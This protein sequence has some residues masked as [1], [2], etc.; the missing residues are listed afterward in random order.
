MALLEDRGY[1]LF[2]QYKKKL[3][4]WKQDIKQLKKLS[5]LSLDTVNC[6]ESEIA[7]LDP[8]KLVISVKHASL[9]GPELYEELLNSYKIQMELVSKDYVLGMTSIC[10][11]EEGF[12]R[13]RDALLEIDQKVSYKVEISERK[14]EKIS[15]RK[16]ERIFGRNKDANKKENEELNGDEKTVTP[17][18]NPLLTVEISPYEAYNKEGESVPLEKSEGHISKEYAYLYPPGIPLVVPGE[19]I[20]TELVAVL[21]DYKKNGLSIKGLK[22]RDYI[23]VV[24]G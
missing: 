8:S 11:T 19:R 1:S 3:E 22:K 10:D 16:R 14:S 18:K 4:A 21:A 23:E 9:T 6:M 24:K 13:L 15:E 20:S 17:G 12:H 2:E 5:C 7:G